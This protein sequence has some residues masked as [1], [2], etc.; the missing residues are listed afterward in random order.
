MYTGALSRLDKIKEPYPE[1]E[2]IKK[3]YIYEPDLRKHYVLPRVLRIPVVQQET[4]IPHL[5]PFVATVKNADEEL[6]LHSVARSQLPVLSKH[7]ESDST[8]SSEEV[9]ASVRP[10]SQYVDNPAEPA[11]TR[12]RRRPYYS[13]KSS[14]NHFRSTP[15]HDATQTRT[16]VPEIQP[17]E[18]PSEHAQTGMPGSFSSTE[19]IRQGTRTP[20]EATETGQDTPERDPTLNRWG[21]EITRL[22]DRYE[23]IRMF[24]SDQIKKA[25]GRYLGHPEHPLTAQK[26]SPGAAQAVGL[27]SIRADAASQELSADQTPRGA[28]DPTGMDADV[29][30]PLTPP[31]PRRRPPTAVPASVSLD[32]LGSHSPETPEIVTPEGEPS[33][34]LSPHKPLTPKTA[35]LTPQT[36]AS[37]GSSTPEGSGLP[38]HYADLLHSVRQRQKFD[39]QT[40]RP[41][42]ASVVQQQKADPETGARVSTGW[43]DGRPSNEGIRK[44]KEVAEIN[45]ADYAVYEDQDA[46]LPRVQ[47]A[48]S[49]KAH[50]SSESMS[51]NGASKDL[52]P[53]LV[54]KQAPRRDTG[55]FYI[56]EETHRPHSSDT[57][58]ELMQQPVT[59][60]LA[61]APSPSMHGDNP[62]LPD[63]PAKKRKRPTSL[64]TPATDFSGFSPRRSEPAT[65]QLR[66]FRPSR[67]LEI[68]EEPNPEYNPSSPNSSPGL[69]FRRKRLAELHTSMSARLRNTQAKLRSLSPISSSRE[70]TIQAF[71][72]GRRRRQNEQARPQ[73]MV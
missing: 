71:Q 53:P 16:P 47:S 49:F 48:F 66:G 27:A 64:N 68:V 58:F 1:F 28:V 31:P 29:S 30:N 59:E 9:A 61:N 52:A 11:S 57:S 15:D 63:A 62:H 10:D 22:Q 46:S 6:G 17:A 44:V 73:I 12:R 33:P 3:K 18:G 36:E 34:I 50:P 32:R 19:S 20:V 45:D 65:P 60:P 38:A 24:Q 40:S 26:A 69:V 70:R 8:K 5:R 23:K 67:K 55:L 4:A 7:L 42:T 41:P 43:D 72:E 51:S 37:T 35:P 54:G 39:R 14:F 21:T 25:S 13:R 56:S 2:H